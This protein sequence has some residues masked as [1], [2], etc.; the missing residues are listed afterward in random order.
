MR[1]KRA[2]KNLKM[3]FTRKSLIIASNINKNI[4]DGKNI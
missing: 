3:K 2:Q 4:K 1:N